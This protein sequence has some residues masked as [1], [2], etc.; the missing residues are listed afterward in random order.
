M[1]KVFKKIWSWIKGL[2]KKC[3][4]CHKRCSNI[5]DKDKY[6]KVFNA[7]VS[8]KKLSKEALKS[9]SKVFS[10]LGLEVCDAEIVDKHFFE[11]VPN[12]KLHFERGAKGTHDLKCSSPGCDLCLAATMTTAG[13]AIALAIAGFPEDMPAIEA[14]AELVGLS[15]EEIEEILEGTKSVSEVVEKICEALHA[16]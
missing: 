7:I 4:L 10:D 2:F 1:K 5:I 15:V 12:L 6:F 13:A 11:A 3:D 14:L 9:P 16:C 8:D